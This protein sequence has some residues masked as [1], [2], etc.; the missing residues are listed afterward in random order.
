MWH[1]LKGAT[2]NAPMGDEH[3]ARAMQLATKIYIDDGP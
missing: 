2:G 3:S 1:M